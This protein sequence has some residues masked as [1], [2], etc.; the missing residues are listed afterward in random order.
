MAIGIIPDMPAFLEHVSLYCFGASYA[1]ALLVELINLARPRPALRIV[2]LAF[3]VA[4]L[5]AQTI[6]LGVR[7]PSLATSAGSTLFL[8][9]ILAIFCVYGTLHHHRLAWGV[10]VLPVV[11][12][13]VVL[14]SVFTPSQSADSSWVLDWGLLHG[15]LLLLG[16]VGV[17][18]AFLA[19]VMY[20]VQAHRL[21][22][23]RLPGQGIKLL[24]LERLEEMNRRAIIWSFPLLTAGMLA[25]IALMAQVADKLQG[26]SDPKVWSVVVLWIAFAI[27]L[28]LRYGFQLRRR[29][30]ALLTIAAFIL[31]IL[32]LTAPHSVVQGGG[33]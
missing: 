11:L 30:M 16:A 10:F 18:V 17:S 12:G 24:S 20:L 33:P 22:A 19:S 26:W 1:V 4:G 23:K 28:Y 15:A 5:L 9:Y 21:R 7:S 13:L 14:A 32:A 6:Y 8:S 31:L 27:L 25:G 3:A 2:S 29:R